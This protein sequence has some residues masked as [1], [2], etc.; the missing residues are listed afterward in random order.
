MF[1]RSEEGVAC[2]DTTERAHLMFVLL[3]P[4]GQPR[5]HQR[6]LA[7]IAGLLHNSDYIHE[8]FLTAE[9]AEELVEVIRAGEQAA[10]G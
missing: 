8:R 3:T 6:L 9:S 7:L 10:L 5:V 4:A 2:A 1:L